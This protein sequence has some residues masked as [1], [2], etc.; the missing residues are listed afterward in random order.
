MAYIVM[1][2][3][4][5]DRYGYGK[6]TDPNQNIRMVLARVLRGGGQR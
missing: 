1:A 2:L 4:S 3:N 6:V 5:C